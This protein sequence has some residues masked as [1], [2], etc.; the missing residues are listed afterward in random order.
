MVWRERRRT[1]LTSFQRHLWL[2]DETPKRCERR[3]R[4]LSVQRHS[5]ESSYAGG[6]FGILGSIGFRLSALI[7]VASREVRPFSSRPG[8]FRPSY[9]H[10]SPR[11]V[12]SVCESMS[13][14]GFFIG[15]LLGGSRLKVGERNKSRR[16]IRLADNLH[17][18]GCCFADRLLDR[19]LQRVG[20]RMTSA[21]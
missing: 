17:H 20:R 5:S 10:S 15:L 16:Y 4:S 7:P 18:F 9:V 1:K 13:S 12:P 14:R 6:R 8:S 19:L 21:T 11:F 3:R 2:P